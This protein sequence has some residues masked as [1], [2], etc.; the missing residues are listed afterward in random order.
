M[1]IADDLTLDCF[2]D[3]D[4]PGLW[5]YEDDQDP[6]CVCS[7]TGYVMTM[8]GCPIHWTSKLQEMIALSTTEAEYIALA[9]AMW[10]FIPMQ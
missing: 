9:Q 3:A 8:G 2:V 7:R 10:E 1:Q 5:S 4:F 6:V